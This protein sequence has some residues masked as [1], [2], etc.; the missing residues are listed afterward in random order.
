MA[1]NLKS[2]WPDSLSESADDGWLN[3]SGFVPIDL[4]VLV[5]PDK[6]ETKTAGGIYIPP[7]T[8]ESKEHAVDKGMLVAVGVNAWSEASRANGFVAPRAGDRVAFAKYGGRLIEGVDGEKYRIMND[9]DV[10]A[11]LEGA[12]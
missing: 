8:V 7:S 9:E 12:K 10:I 1:T 3:K 4:R 2:E 5:R 6:V 11:V